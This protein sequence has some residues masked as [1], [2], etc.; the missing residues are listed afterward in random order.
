MWAHSSC[1]DPLAPTVLIP[2]D[3]SKLFPTWYWAIA[4]KGNLRLVECTELSVV[5]RLPLPPGTFYTATADMTLLGADK[6]R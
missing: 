1:F 3:L 5:I 4:L 6:V 2:S